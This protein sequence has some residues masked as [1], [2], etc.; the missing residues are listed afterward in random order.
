[1][2]HGNHLLRL[3]HWAANFEELVSVTLT[4]RKVYIGMV[5]EV[6]NLEGHDTFVGIIPFFSGYRDETLSM[7]LTVDYVKVYE[8]LKVD[9]SDFVMV[10]PIASICTAG[11]FDHTIFPTFTIE[12]GGLNLDDSKPSGTPR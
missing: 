12:P 6:P 5:T 4:N 11:Y 2:N 10:I 1:M 9:P 8:D 3:L 7:R